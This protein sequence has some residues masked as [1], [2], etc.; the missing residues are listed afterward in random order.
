MKWKHISSIFTVRKKIETLFFLTCKRSIA[1]FDQ[2][3]VA[4][5]KSSNSVGFSFPLPMSVTDGIDAGVAYIDWFTRT[6]EGANDS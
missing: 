5:F 6:T 2:F 3:V 1:F 4:L